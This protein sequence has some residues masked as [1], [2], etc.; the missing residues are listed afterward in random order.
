[1]Y[2]QSQQ[3]LSE[4]ATLF[5]SGD[6]ILLDREMQAAIK[7]PELKNAWNTFSPS[8]RMNFQSRVE[9]VPDAAP[10]VDVTVTA[11]GCSVHP[12]FFP[13]ALEG[14]TG[15]V[16]YAQRWVHAQKMQARHGQTVLSINE[17]KAYLKP[18]GGVWVDLSYLRGSPLVIDEQLISALPPVLARSCRGLGVQGPVDLKTHVTV[19][20]DPRLGEW[21]IVFWDGELGVRS[22]RLELGV[23]LT[24]VTG[25]AACRGRYNGQQLEG[26]VGNVLLDHV[27][28]YQQPFHN[29]QS[30]IEVSQKDPD[31]LILPGLKADLFGGQVYGPVRIEFGSRVRYELNLTASRIKLEEFGRHNLEANTPLSGLASAQVYL[32]GQ[33]SDLAALNGRGSIDVPN[34]RLY[35]LPVLLDLLKFLGLRL[36]DGTAFEEAHSDFTIRGN[37]VIVN[38]IDLYGNSISLRGQGEM[39]LDGTD[40]NLEFYAVWARILQLLPPIIKDIPPTISKYLLKVRMR[41][42]VGNVKLSKEPVPIVVEPLRDFLDSLPGRRKRDRQATPRRQIGSSS[43]G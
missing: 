26:L 18:N 16:R 34:G 7:E 25:R 33:G 9:I 6:N 38:R 36:P 10:D 11:L 30:Q 12:T 29:V 19:D 13:Y 43:G 5:I 35:Y 32:T 21:P 40:L 22:T 23:P 14:V 37:R 41:G 1:A 2:G 28:L 17:G 31:V 20:S 4:R 42:D 15:S 39:N 8:G 24:N 3:G 27:T